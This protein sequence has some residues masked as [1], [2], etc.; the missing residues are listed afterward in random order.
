MPP[1]RVHT[2][3]GTGPETTQVRSC[4]EDIPRLVTLAGICGGSREGVVI[5]HN[6]LTKWDLTVTHGWTFS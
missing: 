6:G 3:A 2:A 5:R 1:P 4:R